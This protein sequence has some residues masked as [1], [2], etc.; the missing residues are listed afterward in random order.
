VLIP[1][2]VAETD[3]Q[4]EARCLTFGVG[5]DT[6]T[7][8]N[9]KDYQVPF[10]FNG[11]IDKLTFHLGPEQLTEREREQIRLAQIRGD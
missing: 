10:P 9:D 4:R 1:A 7:G 5:L 8:V 11:T 2:G 6:G 3:F